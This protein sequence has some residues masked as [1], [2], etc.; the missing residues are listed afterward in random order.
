MGHEFAPNT[1]LAPCI[2]LIHHRPDLYPEPHQ[3]QPERFE[4]GKFSPYQYL[5]FGGGNRRCIGHALVMYEMKLVIATWLCRYGLELIE[6]KP[7]K[8]QRRG[9][10]ITPSGG[11][12]M[13]MRA[14]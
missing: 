12:K 4:S 3:F 1:L 10:T 6:D 9:V 13:V 11:V 8:P 2:Y 7:I 5:P 14:G